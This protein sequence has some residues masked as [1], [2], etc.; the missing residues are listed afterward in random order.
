MQVPATHWSYNVQG[1]PSASHVA[2]SGNGT[3]THVPVL[4]WQTV[5]LHAVLAAGGHI[6]TVTG[7]VSQLP[8]A[9][10]QNKWAWHRS[11]ACKHS[12]SAAQQNPG[13]Q[14]APRRTLQL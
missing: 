7:F 14:R 6:T 11:A 8:C 4:G 3:A 13:P 10:L 12:L 9:R 2:P 5:W 1:L